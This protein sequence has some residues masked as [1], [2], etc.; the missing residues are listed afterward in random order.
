MM[1]ISYLVPSSLRSRAA[2]PSREALLI[3]VFCFFLQGSSSSLENKSNQV[4]FQKQ[5]VDVEIAYKEDDLIRG[6]QFRESLASKHGMLFVFRESRRQGFWMKDTRFP[7]DIIW[8]DDSRRV[9]FIAAGAPPCMMDP[10]PSYVPDKESLYV[11]EV[12]A[13]EAAVLGVHPGDSARFQLHENIR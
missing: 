12:N 5:C 13:G 4:C 10:C 6:L 9:T 8:M 3:I 1:R 7:L 2:S 11:L